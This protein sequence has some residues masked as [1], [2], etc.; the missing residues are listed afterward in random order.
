[1]KE[2]KIHGC[3][4]LSHAWDKM[5]TASRLS[6]TSGACKFQILGGE[7]E[8]NTYHHYNIDLVTI[9]M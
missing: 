3:G 2:R 1:M 6:L 5:L 9:C 8:E 7:C 4:L